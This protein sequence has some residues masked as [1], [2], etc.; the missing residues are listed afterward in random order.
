MYG[1]V[2]RK[3]I[4]NSPEAWSLTGVAKRLSFAIDNMNLPIANL[5]VD[6]PGG[7]NVNV[8]RHGNMEIWNLKSGGDQLVAIYK[9][10]KE[11]WI[12]NIDGPKGILIKKFD[13]G[14]YG[15]LAGADE[16]NIHVWSPD[17]RAYKVFSYSGGL[18]RSVVLGVEE[19]IETE[20]PELPNSIHTV[21]LSANKDY[22]FTSVV[23]IVQSYDYDL[24]KP[25]WHKTTTT[26]NTLY[27]LKT[28]GQTYSVVNAD[29]HVVIKPLIVYPPGDV[30]LPVYGPEYEL[31]RS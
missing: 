16:Q 13:T 29:V 2:H 6:T 19:V 9:I 7:G 26:T 1:N 14:I 3:I 12:Y 11:V 21:E 30:G 31:K 28:D 25:Q 22:Y 10:G 23:S 17:D 4:T 8:F 5:V 20:W 15:G 18:I 27:K 24:F